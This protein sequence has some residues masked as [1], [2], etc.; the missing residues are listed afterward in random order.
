MMPNINYHFRGLFKL[1]ISALDHQFMIFLYIVTL[2]QWTS[3]FELVFPIL[4]H[5]IDCDT[6]FQAEILFLS[7]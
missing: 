2:V 3:I 4:V 1:V 7:A 5:S 6:F